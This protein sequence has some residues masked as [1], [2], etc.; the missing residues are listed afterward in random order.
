MIYPH[1]P[2]GW[3]ALAEHTGD[4]FVAQNAV[5]LA[6]AGVPPRGTLEADDLASALAGTGRVA[7]A[8]AAVFA[9]PWKVESWKALDEAIKAATES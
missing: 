1:L 6:Y 7:D 9:A 8:Q 3:K 4:G 2:H 5:K